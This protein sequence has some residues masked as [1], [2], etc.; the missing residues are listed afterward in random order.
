MLHTILNVEQRLS[1]YYG[2]F[3]LSIGTAMPF[4]ALWFASLGISA[5]FTGT[6]FAAPSF[7]IV[8]F[9]VLIGGWADKLADWRTAIITCNWVALAL[10]SWFLFRHNHWDVLF[11]WTFTGLFLHASGPITDA[12]SLSVTRK[13]G[14]DFARIRAVGSVGFIIGVLAAGAVFD[15][16]GI[17][18]FVAVLVVGAMLR[19]IAAHSLPHFKSTPEPESS[20]AHTL[21]GIAGLRQPGILLVIIGAAMLNASH[22]F[23]NVFAVMHWT[24]LD[25]STGTASVLWSI[26]VVAEV[27]LMWSFASVAKRFSARKCL[28]FAS[29]VGAARWFLTGTE[30]GLVSLVLLQSLHSITFGLTY[31]ACVNFIARRIH[32]DNAAQAQSVFATLITLFM[33]GSVWVSG[34]LYDSVAGK[35]YWAMSVLALC[36]G[37]CVLLSFFSRLEDPVS[38]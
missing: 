36:G 19:V 18:W 11:V 3:F 5:T 22:G 27:A 17:A 25:M 28:L 7:A 14:S 4:A 21:A 10:S 2:V 29:L 20:A 15:V 30:P 32:E 35:S 38:P 23:Y 34:W 24:A 33:A 12:A 13:R 37:V 6:I 8:L 1:F 16:V 9:T 31:L 26:S